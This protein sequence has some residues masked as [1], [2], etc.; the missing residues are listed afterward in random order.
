MC[1]CCI[2]LLST[3]AMV[4]EVLYFFNNLLHQHFKSVSLVGY[5]VVFLLSIA[6]SKVLFSVFFK[7]SLSVKLLLWQWALLSLWMK[8]DVHNKGFSCRLALKQRAELNS[9]MAYYFS[10]WNVI[11]YI[12]LLINFLLTSGCLCL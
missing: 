10:K 2:I 7:G 4:L 3:S 8:T 9:R 6:H 1:F 12:F 5:H 11:S